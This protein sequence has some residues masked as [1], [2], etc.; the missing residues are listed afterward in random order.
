VATIEILSAEHASLWHQWLVKAGCEDVYFFP[1]YALTFRAIEEG[2]SHLFIYEDGDKRLLYPFRL[3]GLPHLQQFEEFA[4]WFDITSDYGYGGPK[5]SVPEYDPNAQEFVR[6]AVCAFDQFCAEQRVVSEFCR[7]HSLFDN[8]QDVKNEYQPIFCNQTVWVDLSL[9]EDELWQQIRKGYRYDIRKTEKQGVEIE[10]GNT[11]VYADTFY[12]L[13]L[14]TMEDVRAREY[15]FF[16]QAF[17]RNTLQL[18]AGHALVFLCRYQ[19]NVIAAALYIW[20]KQFLHY[21]FAC[22]DR[23]YAHIGGNKVIQY[24]AI[25]WG[26]KQEFTKLHLG[27]GVGGSDT[28]SLMLF[29]S[30]FSPL[31]ANFHIAKRVHNYDIYRKLCKLVDVDPD[32]ESFF[33]A[34]RAIYRR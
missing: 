5:I 16:S 31:R 10:T 7:F 24:Q 27:G 17:F 3:R 34:Y 29:K 18:L 21:Y 14:K 9:P 13:Y 26:K 1:E 4:D 2:T 30:G 15:Y 33:P 19:G 25:L 6:N 12:Q 32:T 11:Q 23:K 28:D 8:T 20:G 22:M